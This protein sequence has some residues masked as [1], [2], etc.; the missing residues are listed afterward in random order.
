MRTCDFDYSLSPTLIAQRP[1]PVRD[2]SRLLLL[3]RERGLIKHRHFLDLVKEFQAGDVLVLNDSRVIPARLRGV[4]AK[5]GGAFEV[6]LLDENGRND[7][8]VMLRPGRR[9]RI[10]T[11]IIF[12]NG[13]GTLTNVF[14]TVVEKNDEGHR[15]LEFA[16]TANIAEQI[17]T[18]GEIPLPPYITRNSSQDLADDRERYQTVYAE[19]NGSIAAPTAGLHFTP[20]LLEKIRGRGANICFVTLHVGLGTF[21]PVKSETLSGHKMHTESFAINGGTAKTINEAKRNMRR[22]I[23]VGTTTVRVL[24]SVAAQNGGELVPG[25]GRTSIFIYPPYSFRIVDGL[26]TNFHLPRSTLLML[27]CAFAAPGQTSGRDLVLAAYAEAVRQQYRFYS[28]GDAM[29]IV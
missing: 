20:E 3:R 13:S 14:A 17:P 15:R 21:S 2:Q 28:Y 10:G 25:N 29:L 19:T 18:L 22:V 11:E 8:W 16:G 26:V 7:W 1:T 5:T 4:N 27:V 24:E 9:A 6:L 12:K 23:A